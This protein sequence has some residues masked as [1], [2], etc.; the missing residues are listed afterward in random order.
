MTHFPIAVRAKGK[1]KRRTENEEGFF[2]SSCT[3]TH[4]LLSTPEP[5][6]LNT[7]KRKK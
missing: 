3:S 2:I 6:T 5:A 7:N 1:K 4:V